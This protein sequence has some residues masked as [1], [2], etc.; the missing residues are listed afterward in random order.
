MMERSSLL[1][2]GL[3]FVNLFRSRVAEHADKRALVFLRESGSSM[4]EEGVSYRD[5]DARARRVAAWLQENAAPGERA[6]LLFPPGPE[7]VVG[8]LGCLYAG[9]IAVPAPLTA[10]GGNGA[11]R[12][13]ALAV[14]SQA[15][16]ILTESSLAATVRDWIRHHILPGHVRHAATDMLP[17]I[18]PRAWK[19]LKLTAKTTALLQYTSGSTDLPKGVA[20]THGNLMH[21]QHLIRQALGTGGDI[22]M[23]GWLP[24]F[25]DMGLIGQLLHPLYLGGTTHFMSPL[26]FLMRPH[27]WL[28]AIS[29]FRGTVS[30]AP[31]FAFGLAADR[32]TDEQLAEL[33]LSSLR[34]LCNGSEP[35][36]HDTLQAF[37][38]RF[39][40]AGLDERAILPC[41]GLAESTLFVT[42]TKGRG[43]VTR[44]A[45]PQALERH[46]LR[47]AASPANGSVLVSCG[48]PTGVTAR[49]VDPR[50]R[51]PLPD[52]DVGEIWVRG[53]SVATGYWNRP[54]ESVQTF[55]ATSTDGEFPFLRTGDLGVLDEGELYVIGR[56]KEVLIINGRNLY[57]SD[58]ERAACRAHPAL[59]KGRAA[60][61]AIGERSDQVVLVHEVNAARLR[62]AGAD[63]LAGLVRRKVRAELDVHLTHV[64]MVGSGAVAK[65]TSGKVRR[66]L[67]RAKFLSGE[68]KAHPA[69]STT[70][71]FAD[72]KASR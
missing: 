41:Y 61:F 1:S 30:V 12:C 49:I 56:L 38:E 26:T 52:G 71:A 22:K 15:S 9:V 48:I 65:T 45:D 14:D 16:V 63:E 8:F 19:P 33:D 23:V 57:P 31:N 3:D 10:A 18:S 34:M 47:D 39:R 36:Q 70:V 59:D 13:R 29:R 66:R 55:R 43:M 2:D 6:I 7:F 5:L 11:S 62:E 53:A 25:H 54:A 64:V 67:M 20:V 37:I 24:H 35:V 32:V 46:K 72:S 21:N 69:S 40:H 44:T 4:T 42:G 17:T 51:R 60:A 50:T 68:L 27:R 58:I 28:W